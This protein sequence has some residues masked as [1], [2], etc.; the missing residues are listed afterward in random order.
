MIDE[1]VKMLDIRS[2]LD[3]LTSA[4]NM[5]FGKPHPQ[6]FIECAQA[7]NSKP[8]HCIVFEDSFNGM[9]AAK[10]A[11]MKCVVIPAP[12]AHELLRWH[13]ADVKLNSLFQFNDEV[14]ENL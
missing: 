2:Y 12:Q 1:V 6:V 4:E 14:L 5:P 7:L 11:K 9:I 8:N 10:A 3:Q 13:A